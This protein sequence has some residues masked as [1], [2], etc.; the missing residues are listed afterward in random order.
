MRPN[1]VKQ[2]WREEKPAIGAWLSSASTM[3]TDQ[4]AHAG[5]D[6]L[7]VDGEHS[8][9]D[10]LTAVQ[11]MQVISGTETIPFARPQWNDLVEIKR[12]L[13]GGAYGVVIPWVN[14]KAEAEQAVAACRYPP[15]GLRGMGPYRGVLYGGADYAEQANAEIACVIQIETIGAVE[16]ID[17]ILSVPGVDGTLIGPADLATSLGIP[18]RPDNPHPDHV[19]ACAEVLAGCQRNGVPGGIFTSGTEESVRRVEEGWLFISIGTDMQY[20]RDGAREG[21]RRVRGAGS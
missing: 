2:L 9:V 7:L 17:E 19:A 10:I 4:M 6:W 15:D 12:L 21:L 13:D 3:V 8:P 14:T 1:T 11:M 18:V 5:Y 16:R 20:V